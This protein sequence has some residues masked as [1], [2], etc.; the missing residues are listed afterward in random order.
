MAKT[1][2]LI[3]GANGLVGSKMVSTF[4]DH[5]HFEVM[6][7]ADPDLPVDIT[8][9]DQIRARF[10]KTDAKY[11][12]HLAAFT[13]V[14][15]AWE[16]SGDQSGPAYQVNVNGTKNLIKVCQETGKHLIHISTAYV[17]DGEN[18]GLYTEEDKVSPIE[19]YGQ[20]K[21]WAEEAVIGSNIDWTILRIDQPF[22]S[23]D[24]PKIDTAHR[25]IK[26][27][28][29]NNLYPQFADHFFGPTFIDDFV[30]VIDWVVRSGEK[31]LFHAS[32]G[33]KWSDYEFAVAINDTLSIGGEVKKGNLADYL[34]TLDRP[35][36][37]NTA[38]N[39]S[40]I[41]QKLDFSLTSIRD[42]ID[43]IRL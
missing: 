17:F 29:N 23:D 1:P 41:K 30:R 32:S 37:K 12:V 22:R 3:S 7:T 8:N 43:L 2:L 38:L 31:G 6:D 27:L 16:Q 39:C 9:I 36:Q 26:G 28:Q 24:F 4:D 11:V 25:I 15:A 5:Y 21:A 14:N 42:A 13:N 40:K 18:D 35:Y 19:W 34:K 33:E 20:T 10:A